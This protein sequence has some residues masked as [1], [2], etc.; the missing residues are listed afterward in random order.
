MAQKSTTI[1]MWAYR[2]LESASKH[3]L[4]TPQGKKKNKSTNDMMDN[5]S[6][7]VSDATNLKN[8]GNIISPMS[9]D[10]PPKDRHNIW[11]AKQAADL[12]ALL[13]SCSLD[14]QGNVSQYHEPIFGMSSPLHILR[15]RLKMMKIQTLLSPIM[16]RCYMMIKQ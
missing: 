14:R 10:Q 8:L 6:T 3:F 9:L 2:T 16:L 13:P 11:E 1:N 4:A 12:Q 15:L 7:K 5:N